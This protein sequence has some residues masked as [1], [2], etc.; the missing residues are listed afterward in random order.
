MMQDFIG[1][2]DVL[3]AE[4]GTSFFGAYSLALPKT[5]HYWSTFMGFNWL[6]IT[7]HI[8]CPIS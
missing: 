4:Q 3:I 6:H 2:D 1:G 5:C 8:R 7:S